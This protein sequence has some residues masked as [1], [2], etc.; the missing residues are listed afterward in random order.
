MK[1]LLWIPLVLL[2]LWGCSKPQSQVFTFPENTAI[3]GV[4]V[5]GKTVEE[6]DALLAAWPERYTIRV[7]MDGVET[8]L[9]A[10]DLNLTYHAPTDWETAP[11]LPVEAVYTA[12]VPENILDRLNGLDYS[13]KDGLELAQV[14]Y[15][16]AEGAFV[17]VPGKD[18]TYHD[19]APTVSKLE[20][21]VRALEP[22]VRLH[23]PLVTVPG[24][25]AEDV[26]L[27][28]VKTANAWLNAALT[29]DFPDGSYTVG[30][31]EILP[32]ISIGEDHLT[33][34]LDLT[35]LQDYAYS[36]AQSRSVPSSG[37]QVFQTSSGGTIPLQYGYGGY[38]VDGAALAEKLA[39]TVQNG[40]QAEYEPDITEGQPGETSVEDFGGSYVEV[41]IGSQMVYVYKD[42]ALVVSTPCA[43]GCVAED[44][45]TPT[46]VYHFYYFERDT[47]LTG[48]TWEDW[49]DCWMAFYGGYGLHDA[50]WR[51]EF[52][53]DIYLEHGSHG[54]VNLPPEVAPII[55]DAIDYGTAIILY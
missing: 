29:V 7:L 27:P 22:E 26:D 41:D 5:S 39:D 4:D 28:G 15:S 31:T 14:G 52:G 54:C 1:K 55:Y 50:N 12:E 40:L 37:G 45:D 53:G 6:A 13:R 9:T 2:L 42:G 11:D 38:T 23:S 51:T 8:F 16:E 32:W 21:A 25:T 30:K 43:T 18:W 20:E 10:K 35:A 3:A 47:V 17:V 24:Q 33:P 44:C 36:L 48:P 19:Y 49:V 46:G 34:S